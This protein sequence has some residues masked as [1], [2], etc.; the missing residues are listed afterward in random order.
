MWLVHVTWSYNRSQQS[1]YLSFVS[2][3]RV[4]GTLWL[5]M[6]S[7]DVQ[8]RFTMTIVVRIYGDNS[9]MLQ[10]NGLF[11]LRLAAQVEAVVQ[12]AGVLMRQYSVF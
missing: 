7:S 11:V 10:F 4:T 1:S 9:D 12:G 3:C 2:V 8:G 6:C 5:K